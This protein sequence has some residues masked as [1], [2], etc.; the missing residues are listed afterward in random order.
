MLEPEGVT[1]M[2]EPAT[3]LSPPVSE[4]KLVTPLLLTVMV[5]EDPDTPMPVPALIVTAPV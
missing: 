1:V 3:M 2:F 5:P 4:F